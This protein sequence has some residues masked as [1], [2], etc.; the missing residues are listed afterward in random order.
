MKIGGYAGKV[1]KVDLTSGTI[2]KEPLDMELVKK[3]IGPEGILFRWAY[4]LIRPKID[5]YSE[6]CPIILGSGPVW[7]HP[8]PVAVGCARCLNTPITG[9]SS[10]IPMQGAIWAPCSNGR[11]MII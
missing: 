5:P 8:C 1:L 10:R 9:G 4:D 2:E 6:T 11:A 7:E 3:F